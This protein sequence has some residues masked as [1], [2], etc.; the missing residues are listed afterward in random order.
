MTGKFNSLKGSTKTVLVAPLDWGLGHTTRC[1][2]IIKELLNR[3]NRVI[4]AGN[5]VQQQLLTTEFPLLEFLPLA[6]YGI[7]Y[8]HSR[9]GTTVNLIAQLPALYRAIREENQW[10]ASLLKTRQIDL[11]IS[12]NRYGLYH[13]ALHSIIITHQLNIRPPWGSFGSRSLNDW[14]YRQ[15]ERF[16]ECWVPDFLELDSALA[17]KL[18]HPRQLPA[19]PVEY[20]GPLSRFTYRASTSIPGKIL[21]L[22]SGPEP[23]RSKWE[24]KMMD[25]I[26][27]YTGSVTLVRGLPSGGTAL[28]SYPHLTIHNHLPA[29]LLEEEIASADWVIA[30]SGYSTIMDLVTLKKKAILVPTPGQSEQEYLGGYLMEKNLFYSVLEDGFSLNGSL[31]SAGAFY[32]QVS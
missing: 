8:G 12:D 27:Q 23:A 13:P 4:L 1:I 26:K 16:N 19:L 7:R 31:P 29:Y 9:I 32:R 14:N 21:V 11:V 24:R 10:L 20:I 30:R 2:P 18:S 15:L 28:P 3:G 17:G 22:L 6:G 25:E 5:P